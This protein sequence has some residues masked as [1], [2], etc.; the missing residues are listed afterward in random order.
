MEN[1]G[2]THEKLRFPA[3]FKSAAW[4]LLSLFAAIML[5]LYGTIFTTNILTQL[6]HTSTWFYLSVC[7]TCYLTIA[8]IFALLYKMISKHVKL[9]TTGLSPV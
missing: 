6:N 8:I 4:A 2:N 5:L 3:R 7:I 9:A 1:S